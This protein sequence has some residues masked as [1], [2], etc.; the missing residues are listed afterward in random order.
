MDGIK[1][2]CSHASKV[3]ISKLASSAKLSLL[4]HFQRRREK[5]RRERE[6]RERE[7]ER[8]ERGEEERGR[9]G[10]ERERRR[11]RGDRL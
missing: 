10:E 5:E 8:R 4:G 9:G 3:N 11:G 6:E 1:H 7:E 2:L